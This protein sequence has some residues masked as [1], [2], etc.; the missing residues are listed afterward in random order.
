MSS[1]IARNE[2]GATLVH[3][4]LML[5][6]LFGFSGM[7]IDF[8]QFWV[9]RRQAQNVADAA[10][11][12]GAVALAYD[13]LDKTSDGMAYQ[14]ALNTAMRQKVWGEAPASENVEVTFDC[15]AGVNPDCIRVNVYRDAAHGNPMPTFFTKLVGVNNQG[16]QAT[17]TARVAAANGTKCLKPW[18]LPDK[19]TDTNGNGQYDP[20]DTYNLPGYTEADK[21]T[22]LTI[23]PSGGQSIVASDYNIIANVGD[24]NS[25]SVYES[26]I[27]NCSL[28]GWIGKTMSDVPGGKQG[29]TKQ[30]VNELIDQDPD[31]TWN[32]TTV[33]GPYGL[34]SPRVIIMGLYDPEAYWIQKQN[35]NGDEF[36][37]VNLIALFIQNV[38][39]RG[40]V[41]GVV[42][43][44][45]GDMYDAGGT[46]PP[47]AEFL[48]AIHLVR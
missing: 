23:H 25:A 29:P 30:G 47:G 45:A 7:V 9:A 17:A 44:K 2:Q 32:G 46:A 22:V 11:H 36:V 13:S 31:A 40:D 1:E 41:T 5:V 33:T 27:V 48:S 10:A 20:A 38:S 24:A 18:M 35:G 42:V 26:R 39:N 21:G 14:S 12:A 8:G 6:G 16:V 19:W 34:A 28:T 43:G 4:A 15:P 3:V 37:I